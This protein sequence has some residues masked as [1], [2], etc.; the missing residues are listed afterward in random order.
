ML[1]NHIFFPYNENNICY[2]E[3]RRAVKMMNTTTI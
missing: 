2:L 1:T 3:Q